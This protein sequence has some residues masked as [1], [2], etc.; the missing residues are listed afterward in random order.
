MLGTQDAANRLVLEKEIKDVRLATEYAKEL[1]VPI[2]LGPCAFEAF[3][4][5][6][7]TTPRGQGFCRKEGAAIQV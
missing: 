4:K 3:S 6:I 1:G 7:R 2:T 5:T